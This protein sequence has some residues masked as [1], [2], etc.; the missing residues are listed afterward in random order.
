MPA[1]FPAKTDTYEGATSV[2]TGW[3]TFFPDESPDTSRKEMGIRVLTEADCVKKFGAN[4]L[5]T[6]TQICAGATGIVL[7]MYQ[8]NSGDPL[9]VEHS[10]GL[11]YLAGLASWGYGY[12]DG[13]V[14]T[15][16]SAYR[17]WVQGH[18]STFPS[19]SD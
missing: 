19:G 5:N 6:T 4:M 16:L 14:Y 18:V 1:C 10:N 9:L 7:N 15:S 11:W 3:G 13:H 2:T 17:D 12:A 8:G